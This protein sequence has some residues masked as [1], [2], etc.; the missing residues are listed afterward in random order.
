MDHDEVDKE[1]SDVAVV[2]RRN[3]DGTYHT[4]DLTLEE[5]VDLEPRDTDSSDTDSKAYYVSHGSPLRGFTC[6]DSLV[7]LA[8]TPWES[9]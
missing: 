5:R 9:I 1:W 7:Q 2:Q 6:R 4:R 8:R 3:P